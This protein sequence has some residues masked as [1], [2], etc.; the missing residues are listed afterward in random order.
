M[1]FRGCP[2]L[3][4]CP[5]YRVRP[6]SGAL[7]QRCDPTHSG[8]STLARLREGPRRN[9]RK[10]QSWRSAWRLG[11]SG[12]SCLNL[13]PTG[14]CELPGTVYELRQKHLHGERRTIT[15]ANRDAEIPL[16]VQRFPRRRRSPQPGKSEAEVGGVNQA[17]EHRRNRLVER[18]AVASV[19]KQ[20]PRQQQQQ[21]GSR[22]HTDE[23]LDEPH[24]EAGSPRELK[25]TDTAICRGREAES[26]RPLSH[27]RHRQHLREAEGHESDRQQRRE[28]PYAHATYLTVVG[29]VLERP[30][31]RR[32][33][34]SL[35][36]TSPSP[37]YFRVAPR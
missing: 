15:H 1:S 34:R 18:I 26:G 27:G 2:P 29:C 13:E 25:R 36:F 21:S 3:L 24:E 12:S 32:P 33:Q 16:E 28:N 5:S 10:Q 37:S 30:R 31:V 22:E 20:C 23:W 6:S 7:Q 14:R 35:R 4:C 9:R 8:P 17:E 11:H 19:G